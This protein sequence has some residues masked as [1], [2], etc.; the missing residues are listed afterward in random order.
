MYSFYKMTTKLQGHPP[1][2][3]GIRYVLPLHSLFSVFQ[4]LVSIA[5]LLNTTCIYYVVSPFLCIERSFVCLFSGLTLLISGVSYR[6]L[7]YILK[8]LTILKYILFFSYVH[9]LQYKMHC[10]GS[11]H[12]Y[13]RIY[14]KYVNFTYYFKTIADA[15]PVVRHIFILIQGLSY[16]RFDHAFFQSDG[17][18]RVK[19]EELYLTTKL[20]TV[21][22]I[23]IYFRNTPSFLSSE[24]YFFWP[25]CDK[26]SF[27]I[28]TGSL[29]SALFY[30]ASLS[31]C[32][33]V[34]NSSITHHPEN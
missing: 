1:P 11:I 34:T 6:R 29:S 20:P 21:C 13:P 7:R 9:I 12:N 17:D 25:H 30:H 28:F 32:S 27:S 14:T 31:V 5:E 8:D 10:W 4:I 3:K 26:I 18:Y 19:N 33:S 22:G 15:S 2:F 16:T 24:V 23:A